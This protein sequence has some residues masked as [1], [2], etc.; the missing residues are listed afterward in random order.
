M[1]TTLHMNR[2]SQS[3][4]ARRASPKEEHRILRLTPGERESCAQFRPGRT[5]AEE[6]RDCAASKVTKETHGAP[7]AIQLQATAIAEGKELVSAL[8]NIIGNEHPAV[9][10]DRPDV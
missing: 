6:I 1:Q 5:M 10:S 9:R 7:Y 2:A 8:Q 4:P 3:S